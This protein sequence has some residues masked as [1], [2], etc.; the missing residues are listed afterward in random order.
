MTQISV[1]LI[2]DNNN[3][4]REQV[5]Y[6]VYYLCSILE[7]HNVFFFKKWRMRILSAV[8]FLSLLAGKFTRIE[9]MLL[10]K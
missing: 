3:I 7:R 1:L 9:Q 5:K 10:T 6:S 8:F 2:V 4:Q